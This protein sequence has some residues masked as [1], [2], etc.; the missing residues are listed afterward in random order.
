MK[1][2]GY[3]RQAERCYLRRE[4]E[5][6][7][8]FEITMMLQNPLPEMLRCRQQQ[9]ND[10][11]YL[12]YD[13]TSCKVLGDWWGGK[14]LQ[15]EELRFFVREVIHVLRECDRHLLDREKV[16]LQPELIF[17]DMDA[18]R[19]YF[20]YDPFLKP[21]VNE[22]LICLAQFLVERA[23]Y[24]QQTAVDLTYR[25]YE[26]VSGPNFTIRTLEQCLEYSEEESGNNK[27]YAGSTGYMDDTWSAD[28]TDTEAEPE[29]R[30][31][32]ARK[33]EPWEKPGG[34]ADA[35]RF[36]MQKAALV[37]SF[38]ALAAG[39]FILYRYELTWQE[40]L[41]LTGMMVVA[42]VTAICSLI[43]WLRKTPDDRKERE[44]RHSDPESEQILREIAVESEKTRYL[45]QGELL[46]QRGLQGMGQEWQ[47]WISLGSLPCVIGKKEGYADYILQDDSISRMHARFVQDEN[48][49]Y[50]VDLHS[51][52]GTFVNGVR[53]EPDCKVELHAGDQVG[54]GK[55][56]FTYC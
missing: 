48:R 47:R 13:V 20:L 41:L 55:L 8:S 23:D 25:I 24:T 42:V 12:L 43:S 44:A 31:G 45:E 32:R 51:T 10:R 27:D 16:V 18:K 39:V 14:T 56:N 22:N 17:C 54:F 9:I 21:S 28:G 5:S 4:K 52:N 29:Y 11:N 26:A 6:E 38:F 3:I 33:A 49:I 30:E 40:Q 7:T 46:T 37:V 50:V 1:E 53:L 35:E 15:E 34:Q 19:Y 2:Y 36:Y